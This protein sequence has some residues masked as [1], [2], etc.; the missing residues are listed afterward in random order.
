MLLVGCI[1][2]GEMEMY[3]LGRIIGYVIFIGFIIG[4]FWGATG[5]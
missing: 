3:E 2:K 5:N 1:K 4:I